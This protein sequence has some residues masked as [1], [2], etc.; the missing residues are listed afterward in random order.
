MPDHFGSFK[1]KLQNLTEREIEQSNRLQFL[2]RHVSM[3]TIFRYVNFL[4]VL[5]VMIYGYL[6]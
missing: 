3:P 2:W 4:F 6:F 1:Q 5:L